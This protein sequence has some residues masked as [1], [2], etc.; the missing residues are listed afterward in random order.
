MHSPELRE[1]IHY[2]SYFI[3]I[4]RQKQ[5][6]AKNSTKCLKFSA[7]T[8]KLNHSFYQIQSQLVGSMYIS[9]IIIK[10]FK[11]FQDVTI[12]FNQKVN[13]FT[14]VNNAGKST[15]LEAIS[16]WNECFI[17]L[18][19]RADRGISNIGIE[20]GNYMFGQKSGISVAYTDIISVRSPNYEDIF[21][22]LDR[23]KRISISAQLCDESTQQ[24]LE[25][26]F[27]IESVDGANYYK[28]ILENYN[29]FDNKLLNDSS[30]LKNPDKSI[31]VFHASPLANIPPTE[32]RLHTL[33]VQHLKQ[34][35]LAYLAFRNRVESLY[36][37][38]AELGDPYTKFCNQLSMILLDNVGLIRFEFP[39][40]DNLNIQLQITL[41]S[42]S[43]K[44]ISLVGSGTLQIIEILL[45]I[46][47]Q[48]TDLN[49]I[50]LDE[51]DS[52]IHRSLQA[53]LLTILNS[54]ENT[55]VFITTHNESMIR[56][57][58]PNWLFHLEKS[59]SKVY[60]PIQRDK[61]Q[62]K[63]LLTSAHSPIIQA[64]G[65]RGSGL[66]FITA[67]ESDVI[68]MVEG[69][70]D[71]L[72]IQKILSTQSNNSRKFTYWVMGNVDTIFDQLEHYQKVFSQIKNNKSLWEKTIVVFDK[73]FLTRHQKDKIISEIK[74][75]LKPKD[76][77]AWN[78]YNF[79]STLFSN[80]DILNQLLKLQIN[81]LKSDIDT[82][83][84]STL[85]NE[86]I[87]KLI[88]DKK[89]NLDEVERKTKEQIDKQKPK[90]DK[91][92]L[93]T[94]SIFEKSYDLKENIQSY[95]K[96]TLDAS[97]IHQ[98]MEKEDCNNILKNV[99]SSYDINFEIE[100]SREDLSINLNSL[101][102]NVNN[103]TIFKE[104]EFFNNIK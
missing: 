55:Q 7:I 98:I 85:L 3:Y 82:T 92:G 104:W 1:I 21:F 53:R 46:H 41:G 13:V 25:I 69:V 43:P 35:H 72:R 2:I 59:S 45:N 99:F 23:K 86:E 95:L 75:K 100:G 14:G 37:R 91:L 76:V 88:E 73:D 5:I 102:E 34:S 26:G 32:E 8:S 15:V 54:S 38:R 64:L 90:L 77:C 65:G 68:F 29:S 48:K 39:Q 10:N 50:L 16:L 33:K 44:D 89:A 83:G 22:N 11:S 70:N 42:E 81:K 93:V 94:S 79:D 61:S 58:Q 60:S 30:F 56:E 71:A 47:E 84:L 78:S 52:H 49:I 6:L 66:D 20:K 80:F 96:S 19:R 9:K 18:I 28:I 51:P 36:Y 67:L 12:N 63:G 74:R 40:S 31:K 4:Y 97:E 87:K 17:K 101:F 103:F 62:N 24:N 57:A 27:I